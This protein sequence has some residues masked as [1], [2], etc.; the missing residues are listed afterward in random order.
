MLSMGNVLY[1][2]PHY[3]VAAISLPVAL[4]WARHVDRRA[5]DRLPRTYLSIQHMRGLKL[6]LHTIMGRALVSCQWCRCS[7]EI[8]RDALSLSRYLGGGVPI[9]LR[10]CHWHADSARGKK[11]VLLTIAGHWY[12]TDMQHLCP[13]LH[14]PSWEP[15]VLQRT[16]RGIPNLKWP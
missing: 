3:R 15:G 11:S 12:H 2:E 10:Q 14:R 16:L 9:L 6:Q 1:K 8:A 13:S 7:G 5:D 4:K